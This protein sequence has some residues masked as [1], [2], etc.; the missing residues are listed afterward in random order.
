[1]DRRKT[2][3]I[4]LLVVYA[5][6]VIVMAAG[7][8]GGVLSFTFIGILLIIPIFSC[9][10]AVLELQR[11]SYLSW[12]FL[13]MMPHVP[14]LLLLEKPVKA[15]R[16]SPDM[17]V[18]G[19]DAP[20][21][22]LG[23]LIHFFTVRAH[24]QLGW[25]IASFFLAFMI[26][27]MMVLPFLSKKGASST[28]G[29]LLPFV[30]VVALGVLFIWLINKQE[31][32]AG[33][34]WVALFSEGLACAWPGEQIHKVRWDEVKEVWQDFRDQYVNGIRTVHRRR[35]R[36]MA[37]TLQQGLEFTEKLSGIEDLTAL[38][39]QRVTP[40]LLKRF[41]D[42]LSEGQGLNF[43]RLSVSDQ[44]VGLKKDLLPWAELA[45]VYLDSGFMVIARNARS[46][47]EARVRK[48][49]QGLSA[50][51][52]RIVGTAQPFSPGGD[53]VIWKKTPIDQTPNPVTLSVLVG[54]ILQ[55][56]AP[57]AMA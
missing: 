27:P 53:A 13:S 16:F 24:S 45:G 38:V 42:V 35:C 43:G 54:E 39:H 20:E 11:E 17:K 55:K 29:N 37:Q 19:Q 56:M 48:S 52:T 26:A 34:R 15:T 3:G 7:S 4:V 23:D 46:G 32:K 10:Y 9:R 30:I 5:A 47:A 14:I 1:M 36:I 21:F 50:F 22:A 6:I 2:L 12:F 33:Q 31:K 57:E 8:R 41:G 28:L 40:F 44:G 49:A 25:K 18:A 51:A